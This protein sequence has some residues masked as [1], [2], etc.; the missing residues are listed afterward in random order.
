MESS[1]P[2]RE[3]CMEE[4]HRITHG[5]RRDAYGQP[6]RA[7]DACALVWTGLLLPRLKEGERLTGSDVS[8]LMAALKI[9]REMTG[10]PKRDNIV[11]GIGY[12]GLT[13]EIKKYD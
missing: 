8:N 4:A 6:E 5:D 13:A 11:D 3:T 10:Q 2:T 12:L 9:C 1:V 7:F